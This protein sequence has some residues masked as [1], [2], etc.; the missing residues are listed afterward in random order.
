MS[1]E[2]TVF[3]FI[4]SI[5]EGRKGKN[6]LREC[7]ADSSNEPSDPSSP[8][9]VYIPFIVNRGLSYFHDTILFVNEM[10]LRAHLPHRMQYDFLRD[11]VSPKKRFSKWAKKR[12]L[13]DDIKTIQKRYN[14]SRSKAEAVYSLF[15]E[16]E[17]EKL[18]KLT[19]IGGIQK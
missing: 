7:K 13:G 3:S 16:K 18:R 11:A 14:Y 8:D 2:L 17:L 5:N 6:L 12:S 9:K 1:D 4:N 10:N 19:D 15:S